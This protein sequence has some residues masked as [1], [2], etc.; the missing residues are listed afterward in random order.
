LSFCGLLLAG[1]A[2]A[3]GCGSDPTVNV[4]QFGCDPFAQVCT[5]SGGSFPAGCKLDFGTRK[6]IF[7]GTFDVSNPTLKA[8]NLTVTA[9]QIQVDGSLKARADNNKGG[10]SVELTATDSIVVTGTIDVS[11]NSGGLMRLRAGGR[12]ELTAT[13]T[14]RAKGIET[15][16]T[17]NSA[18]GGAVI[19]TAGTTITHRGSIDVSGGVQGGGGSLTTQAGTDT[20]FTQAVDA[21][22]GVGDG[23]D[24]DVISGDDARMERTL[25]VS[26]VNGGGGGDVSVRAGVDR[27]GGVKVGGTLTV[28][29]DVKS[30]GSSDIDGSWDG[31][32]ITLGA[33]GLTTISGALRA[34]GAS[35]GGSGGSIL[36]DSS[37]NVMT[38]VTALD[39]DL[40]LTSIIDLHGP[41]TVSND[42]SGSGGDIDIFVGR[43]GTI[44]GT[45]DLSG[46]DG[47]GSLDVFGGR[48]V[49]FGAAVNA[50]GT[51][52]FAG[53]GS[54]TMKTGL[55]SAVG[56]AGEPAGGLTVTRTLDVSATTNALAGDVALAGC[57]L[58]L[59]PGLTVDAAV[60]TANV[61][62]KVDLIS[63]GAMTI[64][65]GGT[66]SA[67]PAGR[68]AL[69]HNPGTSPQIGAN[70]TFSP[71]VLDVTNNPA[72]FPP[73]AVCGDSI[74]QPGE[75]CDKGAGAD[76]SC[77]NADCSA[78]SCPTLTPTPTITATSTAPT[79]TATPTRTPPPTI[80]PTPTFTVAPTGPIATPILPFIEPRAVLD[81]EKTI[82]KASNTLVLAILKTLEACSLDAF[83]CVHAKAAG[84]E[85]NA[86]FTSTGRRC[87]SKVAK[88]V[89]S[90]AHFRSQFIAACGGD[91]P[92]VPIELMRSAD[93][94]GFSLLQPQCFGLDLSS[95]DAIVGCLQI[96]SPCE[97]RRA[98]GVAVPRIGDL[99]TL[100]TTGA[101]D[102]GA[103]LPPPLGVSDGLAG[104]PVATQTVRCQR[105]VATS[106]RKLLSRQ[107]ST[108]RS[109]VDSLLK[110]R[111]SGKPREACLKV[112]ATCGRKLAPST[113]RR[114]A[115]APRCWARSA[116]RA[117]RSRPT[118]SV[119]RP[120]S[121][122]PRS[123]IAAPPSA[124]TRRR[125]APR[126]VRA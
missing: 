2:D 39:G 1:R 123:T 113:T 32:G 96:V 71:T 83:R 109:C 75:P 112:G 126:W 102:S 20:L 13:G 92:N 122:M 19:L 125:T 14:M 100:I 17:S 118:R 45:M 111:L 69:I 34:V 31:G 115:P 22:G 90:H 72:L 21:T 99:L 79:R 58:S 119:R 35:P 37:D 64:G 70:V 3:T 73:C 110:C 117:D 5:I 106:G 76:G 95:T 108:A 94:L 23:G 44:S 105:A 114:R 42:D 80:T 11:G 40:T 27:L 18:S 61:Q 56:S 47:G 78:F 68:I 107:F 88:L 38:R 4:L 43:D 86:C 91:P 97:V 120:A 62:P 93:V 25:D 74:L 51:A 59:A 41:Q 104:L 48:T 46:S 87:E 84:S 63:S 10:G 89:K 55:G 116:P 101:G 29:G 67:D 8:Q 53:G 15:G 36:I 7:N 24:I 81:C 49:D 52:G 124:S 98:L 50:A 103:C 26:S 16:T 54:V 33:A 82:G 65:T 85:R 77:C 60:G 121:A 30:N 6:V 9:A 12:I 66:Y 57:T 28:L